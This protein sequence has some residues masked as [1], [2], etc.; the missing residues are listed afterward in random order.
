MNLFLLRPSVYDQPDDLSRRFTFFQSPLIEK[1]AIINNESVGLGA[2]IVCGA[3]SYPMI[4]EN[5]IIGNSNSAY[6]GGGGFY[7]N[8][9]SPTIY[10]N[11]ICGNSSGYGTGI[12][13]H[14]NSS[15]NILLNIISGNLG[16]FGSIYLG[17]GDI[18]PKIINNTN[19]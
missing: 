15:P 9:S 10:K 13:C 1:N 19:F 5:I 12:H 7:C 4:S 3:H 18:A 17:T 11:Y 6:G 14:I 8:D 16:N 2:G